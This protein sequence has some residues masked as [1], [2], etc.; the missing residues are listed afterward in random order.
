MNERNEEMNSQETDM[1]RNM[2]ILH[3]EEV[4]E[5]LSDPK[6]A[7]RKLDDVIEALRK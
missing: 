2:L 6:A 4:K 5:V 1:F 7:E 3:L